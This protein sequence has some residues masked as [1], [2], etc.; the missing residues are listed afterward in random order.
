M[1]GTVTKVYKK[2]GEMAKKGESIVA[3]EA[4]KMELVIKA[5]FDCKIVKVNVAE[6]DFVEAAKPLVELEHV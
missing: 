5:Q 3:M 2:A 1:P 6:G 4:M